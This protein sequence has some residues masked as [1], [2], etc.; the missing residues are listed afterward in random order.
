M[1]RLP[2]SSNGRFV[3]P[4]EAASFTGHTEKP[5]ANSL[6]VARCRCD[7]RVG[8]YARISLT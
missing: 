2:N 3:R 4:S 6:S 1:E 8:A 7:V 5:C